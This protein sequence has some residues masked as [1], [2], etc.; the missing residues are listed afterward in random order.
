[1]GGGVILEGFRMTQI[2]VDD[3]EAALIKQAARMVQVVDH[4]GTVVGYIT[5]APTDEE[6][7]KWRRR[8]ANDEPTYTT[9]EVLEHLRG[10]EER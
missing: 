4:H 5:P 2:I 6:L 10:L 3:Q 1:M 8:L 7:E 9:A